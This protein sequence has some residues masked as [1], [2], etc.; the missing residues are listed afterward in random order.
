MSKTIVDEPFNR[1]EPNSH[2]SLL[3]DLYTEYKTLWNAAEKI[4]IQWRRAISD[5]SYALCK[6]RLLGEFNQLK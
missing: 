1:L 4:Q 2:P 3:D 6:K 5:P